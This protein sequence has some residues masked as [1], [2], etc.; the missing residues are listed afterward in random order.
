[1]NKKR[2]N[3]HDLLKIIGIVTMTIDH[4]GW[5]FFP[6]YSIFHK[7]GRLAMPI[8]CSGVALGYQKTSNFKKYFLTLIFFGVISQ[9]PFNL[10]WTFDKINII[11][12][13]ALGLIFIHLIEKRKY[14][15]AFIP[16]FLSSFLIIEYQWLIP[17]IILIFYKF[18]KNKWAAFGLLFLATFL[19]MQT[20]NYPIQWYSLMGFALILFLPEIKWEF[21]L[22]KYFFYLFYPIH[23]L[24][25]Y[26][27]SI[28]F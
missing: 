2:S 1:M 4:V 23:L 12:N 13:L 5:V 14:L 24:V 16:L 28:L 6:Q 15:L 8:F 7:I 22:N 20:N 17:V 11:I 27:L 18:N 9:F 19:Y 21:S 10:L 26:L 25:L 3:K